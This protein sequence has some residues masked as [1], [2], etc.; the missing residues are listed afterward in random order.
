MS[1]YFSS[2]FSRRPNDGWFRVNRYDITTVD[3]LTALAVFSML[4]SILNVWN[5][6]PYD[7]I[8]IRNG[9]VWRLVTWPIAEFAGFFSIIGVAFFWSFGQQI[10]GLMGRGKF[11]TWTLATTL[12]PGIT[13]A[14]LGV[15]SND[16]ALRR[17]DLGLGMLFLA[18]IW[19]YAGT[20]PKVRFFDVIPIWAVA[21]V[22]TL[23]RVYAYGGSGALFVLISIATA[24]SAGRSLGFAT[25][26]PIPHI[27]ISAGVGSGGGAPRRSKRNK[28]NPPKRPKRGGS[29]QRVVEGPWKRDPEAASP[30]V[31]PPTGP[32]PA[33]QA[34]LDGLLDKIGS[35]GMDALSS[36]EKQRLNELSKRLRN[37]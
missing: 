3:I 8:D 20:Y 2:L 27:P 17:P 16:F 32:S 25:A 24:L 4:I 11:L 10:E 7:N 23:L 13:L 34:E 30:K 22:F 15:V 37:R 36:S 6:L 26:W 31:V 14:V 18:A 28:P 1:Q 35:Q 9:Q 5:Y 33:D 12:V 21:V 29:G 19:V